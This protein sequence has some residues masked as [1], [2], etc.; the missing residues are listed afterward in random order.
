MNAG[1]GHLQDG[2]YL[3]AERTRVEQASSKVTIGQ[4]YKL[5]FGEI[6]WPMSGN[7]SIAEVVGKISVGSFAEH[8]KYRGYPITVAAKAPPPRR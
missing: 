6:S 7:E 4:P 8:R 1:G 3:A 5:P 2:H